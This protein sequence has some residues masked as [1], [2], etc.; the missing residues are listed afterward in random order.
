MQLQFGNNE[1]VKSSYISGSRE[2]VWQQQLEAPKS[3]LY[4]PSKSPLYLPF[5]SPIYFHLP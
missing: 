4:L 5:I 3:P 2:P 1:P